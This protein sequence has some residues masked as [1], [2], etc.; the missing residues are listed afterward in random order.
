MSRQGVSVVQVEMASLGALFGGTPLLN[1][2][3]NNK[4]EAQ[5]NRAV[6]AQATDEVHQE[7]E[8]DDG[9]PGPSSQAGDKKKRPVQAVY[10]D[11]DE[12]E[13]DVKKRL[14]AMRR[15]G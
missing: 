3:D 7:E 9:E 6:W 5:A 14:E 1:D 2:D 13:E 15:A 12:L 4:E 11:E 10:S 8:D